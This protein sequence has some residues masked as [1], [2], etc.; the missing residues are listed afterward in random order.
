MSHVIH[1]SS[2]KII[3]AMIKLFAFV[4]SK[5]GDLKIEEIS[6][7]FCFAKSLNHNEHKLYLRFYL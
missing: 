1:K 3:N 6:Q 5:G 7:L 4:S 2:M